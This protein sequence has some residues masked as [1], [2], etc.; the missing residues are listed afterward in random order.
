MD[1]IDS[2]TRAIYESREF[3]AKGCTAAVQDMFVV[4]HAGA[5][6]VVALVRVGRLD[7][8]LLSYSYAVYDVA[9]NAVVDPSTPWCR[10]LVLALP[11]TDGLKYEGGNL[12]FLDRRRFDATLRELMEALLTQGAWTDGQRQVYETYLQERG[13]RLS[14]SFRELYAFFAGHS[15]L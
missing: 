15:D 5:A 9:G 1:T 13:C 4:Q 2:M 11:S 10:D 3:A 8:T 14:P 7:G 6:Y 12:G